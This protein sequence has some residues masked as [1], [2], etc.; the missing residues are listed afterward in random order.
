[1]RYELVDCRPVP[2]K[3]AAEIRALKAATG[4]VLTSGLRGQPAVDFARSKGCTLSSQPELY[5]GFISGRPGFN[6]ANPPGRS[7]HELR[8]DGVAFAGPPGRLLLYWQFGQDWSNAPAVVEAASRRKWTATIT[9]PDNPREGHHIN[10]RRKPILNVWVF[11]KRGAR[12][13]RALRLKRALYY[14]HS[15]KD[16]GRYLGLQ[17]KGKGR[18]TFGA[19]AERA[20]KRFQ[21]EHHQKADGVYGRQT[22]RQLRVAVR[23]EKRR[24][25]RQR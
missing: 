15:P 25:K 1:M 6:P 14:V 10:F 13:P 4:A 16:G 18:F 23:R 20:L 24:R 17:P 2:A 8:S 22:A 3:M 12:G 7:T 9:Y 19:E 21:R 5:Q 11:I